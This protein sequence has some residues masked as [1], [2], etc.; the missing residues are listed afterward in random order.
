MRTGCLTSAATAVAS[1]CGFA[2][3][4]DGEGFGV[5]FGLSDEVRGD[6]ARVAGLTGDDD[7]GGAGGHVDAALGGDGE[8]GGGDVEVAGADDLVDATDGL[9]AEGEGDD[10][11]GA[12]DAV[13]LGDTGEVGGG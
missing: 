1:F 5:V 9:G 12:A 11:L 10:G 3:D 13:E 6:A 2:G 8:L 7:L 4:E